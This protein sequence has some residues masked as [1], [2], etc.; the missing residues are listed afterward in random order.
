MEAPKDAWAAAWPSALLAGLGQVLAR[1][2]AL[3]FVLV[4]IELAGWGLFFSAF[5]ARE[6]SLVAAPVALAAILAVRGVSAGLFG[7]PVVGRGLAL[8][9]AVLIG[10]AYGLLLAS[11]LVLLEFYKI[12]SS[13]MEPTLMGSTWEGH[14]RENCPFEG[15]HTSP[16]GDRVLTTRV[17]AGVERFDL[18]V[19]HFPLNQSKV[20]VQRAVG[21]PGEELMIHGGDLYARPRGEARFRICRKPQATQDSIWIDPTGRK[22][23]LANREEF[24]R[25]WESESRGSFQVSERVLSIESPGGRFGYSQ[26]FEAG[27]LRIAFDFE[28]GGPG[29]AFAEVANGRGRF[30]ARLGKESEL[31]YEA[32]GGDRTA[33]PLKDAP[34]E[35]GR[36]HRLELAVY[37]GTAVVRLDGSIRGQLSFIEFL[38]DASRSASPRTHE[39]RPALAFGARGAALR[40]RDLAVGRDIHYQGR[41][42]RE[43]GLK[44]DEPV[45]VPDGH[46]VMFGDNVANSHDSR[47]WTLRTFVLKD[48]RRV[49]C[50]AQEVRYDRGRIDSIMAKHGL[51]REPEIFVE[52]DEEGRPWAIYETDPGALPAGAPVGILDR[53]EPTQPFRFVERRFIRGRVQKV[54]WPHDRMGPVR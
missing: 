8:A 1:K 44:E 34:I 17:I 9:A 31:R 14:A 45:A 33:V 41:D 2:I 48:G 6:V 15:Y 47:A 32:A 7:R 23:F 11:R 35:P 18:L 52:N 51:S 24:D 42:E 3:G 50:E 26:G 20:Y 22:G 25:G 19:F 16:D 39:G 12:P 4:A 13:G 28:L 10:S 29:E 53:E 40:V 46:Y 54:W 5:I 49:R 37:D 30:E 36:R 43:H 27:D 38:E 21:M